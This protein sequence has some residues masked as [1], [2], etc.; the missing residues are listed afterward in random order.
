MLAA[1]QEGEG[2]RTNYLSAGRAGFP[3][4]HGEAKRNALCSGLAGHGCW[5][6]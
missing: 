4:R 5:V 1:T 3:T 6:K 2:G